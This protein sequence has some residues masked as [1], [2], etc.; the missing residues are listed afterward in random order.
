MSSIRL[1]SSIAAV[2]VA[3]LVAACGGAAA[4]PAA[5][6]SAAPATAAPSTTTTTVT[7]T[8]AAPTT[9]A[10]TTTAPTTTEAPTTT[11]TQ[12]IGELPLVESV[13]GGTASGDG[14]LV[15]PGTY[16]SEEM[17]LPTRLDLAEQ[18]AFID[19]GDLTF[20]RPGVTFSQLD[21]VFFFTPVGITPAAVAGIHPDHDPLIPENTRRWLERYPDI[22]ARMNDSVIE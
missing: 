8:T 20:G 5:T 22:C 19:G 9:A 1:S 17:T 16:T 3:L 14:W 4:E 18:V 11:T 21:M 15:E 12:P 13:V 7:S 10:P 2:A 6:T